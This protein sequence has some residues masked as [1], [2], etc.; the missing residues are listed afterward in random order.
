MPE[1]TQFVFNHQ[2]ALAALIKAAG[3]HEGKWQLIVQFGF[4]GMNVGPKDTEM[5][6]AALVTISSIGLQRAT[7]ESPVA[8]TADAAIVNPAST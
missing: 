4:A 8:L 6:P 7:K 1:P 3:L 5:F 2:E